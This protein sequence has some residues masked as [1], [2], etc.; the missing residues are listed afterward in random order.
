MLESGCMLE[1]P[2]AAKFHNHV[3]E[4]D[5]DKVIINPLYILATQI[6]NIMSF[7]WVDNS[8]QSSDAVQACNHVVGLH[9]MKLISQI[10]CPQETWYP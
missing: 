3:M 6:N 9:K 8:I 5:W 10:L 1:H 7:L 4:G 2:A